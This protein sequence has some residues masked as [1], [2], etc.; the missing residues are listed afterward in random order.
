MPSLW[1]WRRNRYTGSCP[2]TAPRGTSAVLTN[3]GFNAVHFRH[4]EPPQKATKSMPVSSCPAQHL[5]CRVSFCGDAM[6][7]CGEHHLDG[8]K[9][10]SNESQQE[11]ETTDSIEVASRVDCDNFGSNVPHLLL[12]W[13]QLDESLL[14]RLAQRRLFKVLFCPLGS[15]RT[16]HG[17]TTRTQTPAWR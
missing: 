10:T 14:P 9:R 17:Q 11:G 16:E 1:P 2:R 5:V 8:N 3:A 15:M 4:Q 13:V 12:F 6:A 7:A